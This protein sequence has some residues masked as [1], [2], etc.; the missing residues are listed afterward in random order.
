VH[1]VV[2]L[3]TQL[4][5]DGA[6][7]L[8]ADNRL[9]IWDRLVGVYGPPDRE[10]VHSHDFNRYLTVRSRPWCWRGGGHMRPGWSPMLGPTLSVLA[11]T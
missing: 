8:R 10:I 1:L 2:R 3:A 11:C 9:R 4:T 5:P 7:A 6:G